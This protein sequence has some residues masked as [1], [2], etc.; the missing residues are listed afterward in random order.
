[1]RSLFS[2]FKRKESILL[3]R[4]LL[5]VVFIYAS[6]H[7]VQHPEQLAIIVRSY[8]LLPVSL[9]NLFALFLAWS[10]LLAG[11]FLILGMF[12][13]Q[14][15]SAVAILLAMFVI[16]IVATIA[17]GLVIDCGCFEE[18]G[19]P[20]DFVL[21]VRNLLLIL[22]CFLVIRFDRGFLSFSGLLVKSREG[23]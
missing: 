8:E 22:A 1:M 15:A 7:K 11:A 16:A 18:D 10:E 17:R 6:F 3:L 4:L 13:K 14:A 21:L 23:R 5:G 2:L 9:S 19:H 20:V 12:T